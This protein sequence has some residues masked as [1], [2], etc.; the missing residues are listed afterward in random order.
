MERIKGVDAL[1]LI[2][3]GL[4]ND[5]VIGHYHLVCKPSPLKYG[6]A[7]VFKGVVVALKVEHG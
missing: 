4:G 7:V 5:V 3:F 6:K 2:R 1:C